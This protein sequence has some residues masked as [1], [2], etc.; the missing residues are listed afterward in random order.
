MSYPGVDPAATYVPSPI[1]LAPPA[2]PE[3]DAILAG[4][5]ESR[6]NCYLAHP[7]TIAV[8]GNILPGDLDLVLSPHVPFGSIYR[9]K[10]GPARPRFQ[11]LPP[12]PA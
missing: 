4:L 10:P 6:A 2:S 5:K 1:D 12:G 7:D 9:I 3:V 8:V 11:E